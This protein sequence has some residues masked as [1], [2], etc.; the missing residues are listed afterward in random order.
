MALQDLSL[1]DPKVGAGNLRVDLDRLVHPGVAGRMLRSTMSGQGAEW[2]DEPVI[3]PSGLFVPPTTG[4]FPDNYTQTG[5]AFDADTVEK[6]C[7]PVFVPSSWPSVQVHV[8]AFAGTFQSGDVL[9]RFGSEEGDDDLL[10]TVDGLY[11][12]PLDFVTGPT[13]NNP[14][15]GTGFEGFQFA[16][17]PLV[18]VGD[19]VSDTLD[20]DLAVL[21]LVFTNGG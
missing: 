20:D 9:L 18:R 21:A 4:T 6:A 15:P 12:G 8:M 10:I 19:D 7:M 3:C 2:A 13:W 1:V 17:Y 11:V 16:S 5:I 14:I